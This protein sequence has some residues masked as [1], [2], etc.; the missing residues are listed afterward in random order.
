MHRFYKDTLANGLR[1]VTVEA[2]QLH[3]AMFAVYVRAGSRHETPENSGVSHFLEHIL[4]RGCERFPEGR[5]MNARVEDAGGSL[6]GVTTRD[7]G[8]YYT[9]L[10]P[11]HLESGV[12]TLGAMLARPLLKEIDIEREVILEEMLDEVDEDGRDIDIDNLSKRAAFGQHPLAMKI[13]GTRESV[14]KLTREMLQGHHDRFYVARN[15]VVTA[16]GPVTREEILT[17]VERHFLQFPAGELARETPPPAWPKGPQFIEVKH[18]ESQT[19]FRLAFPTPPEDHPDFPALMVLRRVL[20][21]G[22][23]SRLQV[24]IVDR[25]GLA[26]SI[27]AGF[28]TFVDTGSFEVDVACAHAKVPATCEEVLQTLGELT[29]TLVPD[30]EIQRAKNRFRIGFDFMLDSA[31]DLAGWYG[32]TELFRPAQGFAERIAEVDAVT[33]DDVRR[34]ARTM[35]R[36]EHLLA[37]AVGKLGAVARRDLERIVAAAAPLP[38]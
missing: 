36:R 13:A 12:E 8:Y 19:E 9:P 2:P 33:A 11:R 16:A 1:V 32:G 28:D 20:D 6:N 5:G 18:D 30:D 37:I 22:L 27:Q 31:A 4:F 14:Q 23:S 35:L 10:H 26:Y 34:V 17:L 3:S 7:H 38:A 25:K 29:D 24:N 21:D 15:M